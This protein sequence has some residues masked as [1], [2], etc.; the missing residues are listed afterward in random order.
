MAALSLDTRLQSSNAAISRLLSWLGVS[1]VAAVLASPYLV[2][3]WIEEKIR[4]DIAHFNQFSPV[5]ISINYYQRGWLESTLF[6]QASLGGVQFNLSHH[7]TH[8]PLNLESGFAAGPVFL[9][10][11]MRT[12]P[13][14]ARRDSPTAMTHLRFNGDHLTRAIPFS[15]VP[16]SYSADTVAVTTSTV[17]AQLRR[18][19]EDH[20]TSTWANVNVARLVGR[21]IE[22]GLD[23]VVV[24]ANQLNRT[25]NSILDSSMEFGQIQFAGWGEQ[26]SLSGNWMQISA[27]SE[28]S[29]SNIR[30]TGE[31]SQLHWRGELFSDVKFDVLV[32]HLPHDQAAWRALFDWFRGR[33]PASYNILPENNWADVF[34]AAEIEVLGL[35]FTHRD[36]QVRGWLRTSFSPRVL[37][38]EDREPSTLDS[39]LR[40]IDLQAE[41][42]ADEAIVFNLLEHRTRDVINRTDQFGEM[43]TFSDEEA[44]PL[45]K[46]SVESQLSILRRQRYLDY[47]DGAYSAKLAM[48]DGRF[49]INGKP[50]VL[51]QFVR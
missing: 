50:L 15:Y 35:E 49:S 33:N 39:L 46:G 29:E 32:R 51:G 36:K 44:A 23:D 2:G 17:T 26:M 47:V 38:D 27:D 45:V 30:V 34:S 9:L 42:V 7:I 48:R 10:A 14:T 28:R 41:F 21:Q 40:T 6:T 18:T 20:S 22:I 43:M 4:R 31:V 24:R 16:T 12:Q 13:L 1:L 3:L 19:Q 37:I 11:T 5:S 25:G 8:G